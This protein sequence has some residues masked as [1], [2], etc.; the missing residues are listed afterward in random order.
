M[1]L[2]S[3]VVGALAVARVTWLLYEDRITSPLRRWA[4]NKWGENSL[5]AYMAHC[6][7]CISIWVALFIMPAAA[8]WP[9]KWVIAALAVPA[10]SLVAGW[11]A[12]RLEE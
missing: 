1:I 2:L 11:N 3:L 10:A 4:V 7:W 8:L 9:N 6:P 5:P 12:K